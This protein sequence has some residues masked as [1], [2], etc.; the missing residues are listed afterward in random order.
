MK[1]TSKK[2]FTVK[3]TKLAQESSMKRYKSQEVYLVSKKIPTTTI[4]I[5]NNNHLPTIKENVAAEKRKISPR[6][7][8][9]TNKLGNYLLSKPKPEIKEK[10]KIVQVV[11]DES[12]QELN[13][14]ENGKIILINI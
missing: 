13:S 1:S 5:N 7:S 11:K 3:S 8:K 9:I 14:E 10:N 6:N 12:I 4:N 2:Q